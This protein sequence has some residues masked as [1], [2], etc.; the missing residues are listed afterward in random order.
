MN[1]RIDLA[2]IRERMDDPFAPVSAADL[3]ALCDEVE[4]L[5]EENR[6][7]GDAA[8]KA[9]DAI[10]KLCGCPQWDY[11]GQVVRDVGAVT[12][13]RDA[14]R[15]EVERLRAENARLSQLLNDARNDAVLLADENTDLRS[16]VDTVAGDNA[17]LTAENEALA[18]E[19]DALREIIAG[20][21][22][23]PTDAEIEAHAKAGGSWLYQMPTGMRSTCGFTHDT[24]LWV[25]SNVDVLR[26]WALGSDGAPCAWPVVTT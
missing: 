26:W 14:L 1:D 18:A 24:A 16:G 25:A 10:A 17:D 19:R 22:T 21:T 4:R 7:R 8:T 20:R 23:P 15:A 12:T 11:P 6:T 2:A 13:E 5:T 9:L 3:A